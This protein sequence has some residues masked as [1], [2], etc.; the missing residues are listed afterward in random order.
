MVATVREVQT[1]QSAG[2]PLHTA[3]LGTDAAPTATL[4]ALATNGPITRLDGTP[5]HP[6][7]TQRGPVP[8]GQLRVGD[9]VFTPGAGNEP[10]GRVTVQAAYA[11]GAVAPR[12]YHLITTARN[13]VANGMVVGEK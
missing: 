8:L 1:H 13:Y 10:F 4:G 11:S 9:V 6:I 2:Y 3:W 7:L 5:N 12:V